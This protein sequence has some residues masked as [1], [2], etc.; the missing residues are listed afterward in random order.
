MELVEKL[1]KNKL[2][3]MYHLNTSSIPEDAKLSKYLLSEVPGALTK[4]KRSVFSRTV[5]AHNHWFFELFVGKGVN[6]PV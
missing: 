2:A 6:F 3:G 1:L 5:F 4:I